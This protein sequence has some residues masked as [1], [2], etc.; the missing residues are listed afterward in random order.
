MDLSDIYRILQLTQ[1]DAS[2]SHGTF[3]KINHILG[4]QTYLH[5]LKSDHKELN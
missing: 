3:T 4:Y 1:Q 5:K 2:S